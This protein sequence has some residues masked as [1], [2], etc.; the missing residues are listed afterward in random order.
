MSFSIRKLDT[1]RKSTAL[2]EQNINV[3]ETNKG[4]ICG[5]F[6]SDPVFNLSHRILTETEIKV[7]KKARTMH[8]FKRK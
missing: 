5:Y 1:Y 2:T 7:L 4:R 6:C 8:P 3:K